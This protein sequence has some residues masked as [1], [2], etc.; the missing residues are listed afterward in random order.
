M[1]LYISYIKKWYKRLFIKYSYN[2]EQE[3]VRFAVYGTLK[4]NHGNNV[5]LGDA[6]YL[7]EYITPPEYTLYDGGFPVVERHGDT[8]IHCE[9][10]ETNDPEIIQ[11]VFHLEG[12]SPI[13][14]HPNNWYDWDRLN[15]PF[16]DA[17]IFVMDKG[18]SGRKAI[19]KSGKWH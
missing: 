15:T 12:S 19:V 7:G 14:H 5:V 10:F 16:G 6:K 8:A 11:D 18:E 3:T 9:V 4:K 1:R 2:M 13:Q 17:K